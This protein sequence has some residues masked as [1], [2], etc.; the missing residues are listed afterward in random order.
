MPR[1]AHRHPPEI[2]ALDHDSLPLSCAAKAC[3]GAGLETL[4]RWMGEGEADALLLHNGRGK[5]LVLVNW[6]TW[7]RVARTVVRSELPDEPPQR[8]SYSILANAR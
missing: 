7:N 6:D 5:P 1:S 8:G 4:K 3:S 2:V